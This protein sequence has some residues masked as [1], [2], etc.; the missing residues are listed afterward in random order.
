MSLKAA[1]YK[2]P[3]D[4]DT[5][6]VHALKSLSVNYIYNKLSHYIVVACSQD[7]AF[8]QSIFLHTGV[9]DTLSIYAYIH[10]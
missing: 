10:I 4:I 7:V 6:H 2:R 9:Q 5:Y 3:I 8:L 1:S